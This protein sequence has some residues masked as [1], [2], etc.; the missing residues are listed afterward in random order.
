MALKNDID[1]QQV[2]KALGLWIS[3]VIP[4]A[5][6]PSIANLRIPQASGLSSL[7]ILFDAE[8]TVDGHRD[9]HELVVRCVP[10]KGGVFETC[11]LSR[12]FQLFRALDGQPDVPVPSPVALEQDDES[13]IGAPFFVMDRIAGRVASDDPPYTVEGWVMELS[14]EERAVLA[15]NA[16]KALVAVHAVDVDKNNLAWLGDEGIAAP[17]IRSRLAAQKNYL[18]WVSKGAS[19]PVLERAFEWLEAEVPVETGDIVISWG[20]AR[21]GNLIIAEDLKVAAII[22]WEMAGLGAREVDLG[23]WLLVQ[24]FHSSAIG[25][26]LPDGFLS[27]EE[28]ITLYKELSGYTPRNL[29]YYITFAALRL[30]IIMVRLG[31]MMIEHELLPPDAPMLYNNPVLQTLSDLLGMGPLEGSSQYFVGNR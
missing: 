18:N 27:E 23:W 25:V 31:H 2:S 20:D 24:R 8:W 11:D 7:T 1:A 28:T 9:S 29:D 17:S 30:S 12:E 22:D 16:L 3:R 5:S 6:S 10:K 21:L 26:D 19:H 4:G 13:I 14:S 15:H